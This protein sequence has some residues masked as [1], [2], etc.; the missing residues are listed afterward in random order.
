[1]TTKQD[2]PE[3]KPIVWLGRSKKDLVSFP[4]SV[5]HGI[6]VALTEAQFGGRSTKAKS[7]R[8]M[9]SGVIEIVEDYERNTYRAVYLL[10]FSDIVYVLHCFQKKSKQGIKTP[11]KDLNI[12]RSRIKEAEA[13]HEEWLKK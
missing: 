1:M 4:A 9:G 2:T 12:I 3:L 11:P 8:G 6:G 13:H 7:L 5:T 10:R